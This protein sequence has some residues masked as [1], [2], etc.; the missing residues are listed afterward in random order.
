MNIVRR[1]SEQAV[2]GAGQYPVVAAKKEAG[3]CFVPRGG[4]HVALGGAECSRLAEL[5]LQK[6]DCCYGETNIIRLVITDKGQHQKSRT[7]DSGVKW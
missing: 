4:T 1:C 7:I 2:W 5:V 3:L 6:S